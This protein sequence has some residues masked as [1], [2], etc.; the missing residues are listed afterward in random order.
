MQLPDTR[1]RARVSFVKTLQL[2]AKFSPA[3]YQIGLLLGSEGKTSEAI[4]SL[5]RTADP[6]MVEAHRRL[7][8]I[9]RRQGLFDRARE[10]TNRFQEL[11]C[12]EEQSDRTEAITLIRRR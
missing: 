7:S 4:Q 6:Q 10:E 2:D 8:A 3:H 11:R 1:E 5:E 9:Y 12:A